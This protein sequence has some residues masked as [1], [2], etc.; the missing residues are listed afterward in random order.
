MTTF[1][2][3]A[4]I[5]VTYNGRQYIADCLGSVARLDYPRELLDIIVVDSNSS[6]GTVDY[7]REQF[8]RAKII[9]NHHNAGFAAANNQGY[10]IARKRGA[11]YIF[12][13]NQDTII[14]SQCLR[15]LV[16]TARRDARVAAIQAKLLLY[17][18]KNLINSLGNNLHILGFGY[19]NRYREVDRHGHDQPFEVAYPSGAAT[20]ISMPALET[21]GLF[22]D[23]FFMYHEDVD[24]GWRLRLAGY[25]VMLDPLAVVYHKY[26]YSKAVYKFY[27]ME[28]NRWLVM[29][30]NYRVATL[31]LLAPILLVMELGLLYFAL[32]HGW[33]RQKLQ[34]YGWIIAHWHLI[35]SRRLDVQF[36]IRQARDREM[37][38]LM[39][40][41][42]L[43][44][45]IESPV[46]NYILNPVLELYRRLLRLTV[47]W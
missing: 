6:D 2:R 16:E 42:I 38:R 45:E 11:G 37:L 10:L 26:S 41:S 14:D 21:T 36:R 40:G 33:L 22:A 9:A 18:E 24:L 27:Y 47:W 35:I 15:R 17:P 19:C 46:V 7:V 5:I 34:G 25:R 4:I 13:L 43:F 30:M 31:L 1:P 3:I 12:L 29:L 20:L 39:T 28:R 44:Q 8:P 23:W 32:R